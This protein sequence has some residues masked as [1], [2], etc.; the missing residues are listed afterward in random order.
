MARYLFTLS[1]LMQIAGFIFV[2]KCLYSGL[3]KG[4]YGHQELYE[5]V[6]GSFLF[7]LGNVLKKRS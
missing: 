4:D 6:G 3:Q 1:L 2:T 5:F 7:Y